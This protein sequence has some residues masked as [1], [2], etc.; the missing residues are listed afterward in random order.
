MACATDA[1]RRSVKRSRVN[2]KRETPRKREAHR[3]EPGGWDELTIRLLGRDGDRCG[4]CGVALRGDAHRH[5]RKRRRDGGDVIE[6]LVL[7]HARCHGDVHTNVYDAQ[8]RGFIVP[9]W[10]DPVE[11]PVDMRGYGVAWLSPEGTRSQV[12]P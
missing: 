1:G 2:P 5:H 9:T 12:S 10:A 6:N 11:T 7:L 3:L 8:E 4:W